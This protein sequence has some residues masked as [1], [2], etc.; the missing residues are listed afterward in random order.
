MAH[1]STSSYAIHTKFRTYL[2]VSWWIWEILF[3]Q[4]EIPGPMLNLVRYQI[5][6]VL[7]VLRFCVIIIY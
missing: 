2:L 5:R 4:I 7:R 1:R 3:G 6:R